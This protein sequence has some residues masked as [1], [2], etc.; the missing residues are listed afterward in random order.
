MR[1]WP[2][3]KR[4]GGGRW[5]RR[6]QHFTQADMRERSGA[7]LCCFVGEELKVRRVSNMPEITVVGGS[8]SQGFCHALVVRN[9]PGVPLLERSHPCIHSAQDGL[10]T[11]PH[12]IHL[13]S[14][15]P[16]VP[17]L[18]HSLTHSF[19]HPCA[20]LCTQPPL[21]PPCHRHIYTLL[22]HFSIGIS[23]CSSLS[24]SYSPTHSPTTLYHS[25][26]HTPPSIHFL[27]IFTS[28]HSFT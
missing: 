6:R 17:S 8:S 12:I 22:S 20:P 9:V 27:S 24:D 1:K 11:Y 4:R 16:S 5:G 21:L 13:S 3:T 18:A 15:M 19:T 26:I 23:L 10:F 28:T 14:C 25:P 7:S 2:L